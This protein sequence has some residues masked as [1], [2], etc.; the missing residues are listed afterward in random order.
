[1]GI[2]CKGSV[3]RG[4]RGKYGP[5]SDA[6]YRGQKAELTLE[7]VKVFVTYGRAEPGRHLWSSV[8]FVSD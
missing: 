3:C 7:R 8:T 5:M 6:G 2:T 1:M 4:V